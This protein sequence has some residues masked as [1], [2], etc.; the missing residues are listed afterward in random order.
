MVTWPNF[1]WAKRLGW[2]IIWL[3]IIWL[4]NRQAGNVSFLLLRKGS[5]ATEPYNKY[6][7]LFKQIQFSFVAWELCKYDCMSSHDFAMQ[8]YIKL[9]L[10]WKIIWLETETRHPL[11]SEVFSAQDCFLTTYI[12]GSSISNALWKRKKIQRKKLIPFSP[13][14]KQTPNLQ[15]G[16]V[17]IYFVVAL[18]CY[19]YLTY[20]RISWRFSSGMSYY[21]HDFL[22]VFFR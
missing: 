10:K 11:N 20:Q 12:C 22:S 8:F 17:P 19:Q 15:I 4:K 6:V 18:W 7:N 3:K 9:C 21:S 1:F 5:K 2:M 14:S 13:F 16:C